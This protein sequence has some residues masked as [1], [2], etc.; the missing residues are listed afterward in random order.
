MQIKRYPHTPHR[1]EALMS[2]LLRSTRSVRREG[3]GENSPQWI[4]CQGPQNKKD[5]ALQYLGAPNGRT[6]CAEGL[7]EDSPQWIDCQGP[8]NKKATAVGSCFL[9]LWSQ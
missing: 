6:K 7:G 3:F 4:D 2:E 5:T 9:V 1:K 8:Q